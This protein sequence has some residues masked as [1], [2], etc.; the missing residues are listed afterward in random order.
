MLV[1]FNC[2]SLAVSGKRLLAI[3]E[4]LPSETRN[5]TTVIDKLNVRVD[6]AQRWSRDCSEEIVARNERLSI[7]PCL[8]LAQERR[9]LR[10]RQRCSL[11]C[12]V[13]RC[14]FSDFDW[15]LELVIDSLYVGDEVV[16]A[17]K[18]FQ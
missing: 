2:T 17:C 18:A 1:Y 14:E 5:R 3:A 7:K 12:E 11:V 13:H 9:D 16:A 6:T 10:S 8:S 4:I 15:H